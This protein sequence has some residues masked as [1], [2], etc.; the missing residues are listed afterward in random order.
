MKKLQKILNKLLELDISPQYS[1]PHFDLNIDWQNLPDG[2][3]PTYGFLKPDRAKRKRWQIENFVY[4][5]KNYLDGHKIVVDFC[6]GSG[7]LSIPMAYLFPDC[8][9]LLVERNPIPVE[10]GMKRIKNSGLK[11]IEIFNENIVDFHEKFDLGIAL[12]A[13]G[14]ATDLAQEKCIQNST[15]YILCPC[16]IGYIQNSQLKYPRSQFFSEIL[17]FDE[18]KTIASAADMTGWDFDSPQS[19]LGKICMGYISLDR[20]LFAEEHNYKTYLFTTYPREA[21]PKNDIIT[22]HP[23]SCD[24]IKIYNVGKYDLSLVIKNYFNENAI[25]E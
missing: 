11:N 1:D 14:E 10:I 19:I 6:S 23:E 3:D 13:C 24:G 20:N 5:A 18:Y 8:H 9:F 2:I 7:H 15:P 12:H 25:S 21:T 4:I 16:D 22:G 17:S